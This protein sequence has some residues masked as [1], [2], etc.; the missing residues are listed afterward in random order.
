MSQW[1]DSRRSRLRQSGASGF[2]MP[3]QQPLAAWNEQR[4]DDQRID[5]DPDH[6]RETELT[7]LTA[8]IIAADEINPPV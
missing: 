8:V 2:A 7:E 5:A 1:L 4:P 3:V 6:Q